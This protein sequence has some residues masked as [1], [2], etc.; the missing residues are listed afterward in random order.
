MTQILT[1]L[2]FR[3]WEFFWGKATKP[4]WAAIPQGH[5]EI[6]GRYDPPLLVLEDDIELREWRA[7]IV[8]PVGTELAYL[9][10]FRC[11]DRLGLKYAG[12]ARREFRRA[13]GYGYSPICMDWM[14]IFSMWGT[15]AILY[16]SRSA[17]DDAIQL[18]KDRHN[19]IDVILAHNQ[20][21]WQVNCLRVPIFWQNDGHH[22]HDTWAYDYEDPWEPGRRGRGR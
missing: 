19:C 20:W 12:W 1:H 8:P 17:M 7:N 10:G 5:A 2:G 16:L 21:R 6:L 14:R 22:L 3:D 11:S 4:Y 18:W 9:G 13:W 15:H